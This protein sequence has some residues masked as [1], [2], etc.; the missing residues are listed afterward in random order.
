[1]ALAPRLPSLNVLGGPGNVCQ[2]DLTILFPDCG[3]IEIGIIN[4]P[5]SVDVQPSTIFVTPTIPKPTG[6]ADPHPPPPFQGPPH[7]SPQPNYVPGVPT[8]LISS[9]LSESC[10][11]EFP[12]KPTPAP[13]PAQPGNSGNNAGASWGDHSDGHSGAGY[14]E[15]F[16]NDNNGANNGGSGGSFGNSQG[17]S[18][19]GSQGDNNGGNQGGNQGNN[20]NNNGKN[21]GNNG[22][23]G[24]GN[25]NNNNNN[26]GITGGTTSPAPVTVSTCSTSGTLL[27]ITVDLLGLNI[28]I[29]A[30]LNLAGLLDTVGDLVGGLLGGLLG[31]SSTTQQQQPTTVS[32]QYRTNCGK[33][34]SSL[35]GGK[36]TTAT[37]ASD[38]LQKCE[39]DAIL[40]TVQLGSLNDCLGATLD[41]SI[42]VDNCLYF[43]G[44]ESDILDINLALLSSSKDSYCKSC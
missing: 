29:D 43:L 17:G 28:D 15:G 4:Q 27:D 10:T 39:A 30:Y 2:V 7:P 31:G 9:V 6:H 23:N 36:T 14:D 21:N 38:C 1:M 25:G 12:G 37:S 42:A 13:Y 40:L 3:S 22:N 5:Y 19:G 33:S 8:T 41:N 24:N 11:D 35:P 26:G 44:G 20:N 16:D 34:F 32:Q 18:Q